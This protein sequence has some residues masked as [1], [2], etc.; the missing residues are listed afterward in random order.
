MGQPGLMGVTPMRGNCCS[1]SSYKFQ[2]YDC[3][4]VFGEKNDVDVSNCKH[5]GKFR[6]YSANGGNCSG[7]DPGF[8]NPDI[9][10][11]QDIIN[12]YIS[13]IDHIFE[14]SYFSPYSIEEFDFHFRGV[15]SG[16]DK[17]AALK[18]AGITIEQNGNIFLRLKDGSPYY[19]KKLTW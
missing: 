8:P 9:T 18:K 10:I 4:A 5:K 19:R 14:C 12:R 11:S 7:Y 2:C 17:R 3:R 1:S 13:F 6:E 16:P 15:W